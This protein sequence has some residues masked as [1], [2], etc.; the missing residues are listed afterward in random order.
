MRDE[1]NRIIQTFETISR[2]KHKITENLKYIGASVK[3]LEKKISRLSKNNSSSV[4]ALRKIQRRSE[5]EASEGMFGEIMEAVKAQTSAIATSEKLIAQ[6]M[7]E[8]AEVVE[9]LTNTTKSA[10]ETYGRITRTVSRMA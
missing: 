2:A 7:E 1:V 3:A 4:K 8:F 5:E 6:M 10:L 9:T